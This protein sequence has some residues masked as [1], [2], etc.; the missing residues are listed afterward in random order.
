M[1]ERHAHRSSIFQSYRSAGDTPSM[2]NHRIARFSAGSLRRRSYRVSHAASDQKVKAAL[3]GGEYVKLLRDAVNACLK[4]AQ[5][6]A[7]AQARAYYH[8]RGTSCHLNSD[9]GRRCT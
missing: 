9:T 4:A 3:N 7:A 6:A 2:R 5:D 1:R 8:R